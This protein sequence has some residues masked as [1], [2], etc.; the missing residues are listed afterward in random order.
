MGSGHSHSFLCPR[1]HSFLYPTFYFPSFLF[2]F[3]IYIM[4][5]STFRAHVATNLAAHSGHH[6]HDS[7]WNGRP[8]PTEGPL[9]ARGVDIASRSPRR[10]T[11]RART[12]LRQAGLKGIPTWYLLTVSRPAAAAEAE[13]EAQPTQQQQELR[14]P[15]HQRDPKKGQ[16]VTFGT[17]KTAAIHAQQKPYDEE[18]PRPLFRVSDLVYW[19][20]RDFRKQPLWNRRRSLKLIITD[21][22]G[23]LEIHPH[24]ICTSPSEIEPYLRKTVQGSSEGI[25]LKNPSSGYRRQPL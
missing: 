12:P 9:P 23:R 1:S 7:C 21:I 25:M 18:S 24:L 3:L 19:S 5:Q 6:I 8:F 22:P 11:W 10:R 2:L 13:A 14:E 4:T 16:M 15:G 17:L 20:D